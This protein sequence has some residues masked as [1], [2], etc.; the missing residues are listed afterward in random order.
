M[1]KRKAK[2]REVFKGEVGD[3][4]N[5]FIEVYARDMSYEMPG[6]QGT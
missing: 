5:I 6:P 1:I 4:I 2:A 3:P